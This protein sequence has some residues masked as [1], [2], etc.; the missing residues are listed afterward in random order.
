MPPFRAA[1]RL[2][3]LLAFL[4][5]APLGA[6]AQADG[7]VGETIE[8]AGERPGGS[9]QAPSTAGTTVEVARFSGEVRSA[10]ELLATSPGATVH[11]SGAPGQS[12][13]LSLRGASADESLI[14]LDGIPLQGPGGGSIDLSTVPAALL[15]RMIVSRGVLGA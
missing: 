14:L 10:A 9:P 1:G 4:A 3:L 11:Q 15:D 8:V 7:G 2:A 6:R 5:E 12:A 13:S